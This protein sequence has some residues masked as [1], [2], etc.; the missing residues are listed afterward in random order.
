MNNWKRKAS[1]AVIILLVIIT[2]Y[3]IVFSENYLVRKAL[4]P[5]IEPDYTSN[6]KHEFTSP[7][8]RYPFLASCVFH[9]EG[10]PNELIFVGGGKGQ[11]DTILVWDGDKLES[12]IAPFSDHEATYC[13]TTVGNWDKSNDSSRI[14]FIIGRD[15]GVF[16]YKNM[17]VSSGDFGPFSKI[18]IYPKQETSIPMSVCVGDYNKDGYPD[19][20]ISNFINK[21]LTRI[22]IFN[23]PEHAK[24]NVMMSYREDGW[25]DT[26]TEL[27]L[28]GTQNTF[29]SAFVDLDNN[30]E[31]S[32]V[33]SNDTGFVEIHKRNGTEQYEIVNPGQTGYGW[34][35]GLGI[36]DVTGNGLQDIFAT[37]VGNTLPKFISRGDM[38]DEQYNQKNHSHILL[39]NR[40]NNQFVDIT[41]AAGLSDWGFGWSGVFEDMNLD[42]NLD[43]AFSQNY[44]LMNLMKS[45][46]FRLPGAIFTNNGIDDN[47]I[48]QFKRN[49]NY[50]SKGFGQTPLFADLNGNGIKDLIWVNMNGP[51]EI[52]FNKEVKNN[53]INVRIPNNFT[54]EN[55]T[56]FVE[57]R[58]GKTQFRQNIRAIGLGSD[59]SR[60]LSFGLGKNK[61]V[62]RFGIRTIYGDTFVKS[63]PEINQ[64]HMI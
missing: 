27:N 25:H 64:T 58:F 57:P 4:N 37:N 22:F 44:I 9:L 26:T 30:G 45:I 28:S 6:W 51:L 36:G 53:F 14:N 49:Y 31:L 2:V 63:N 56:V 38:T 50:L 39:A 10:M 60:I 11:D 46:T 42:G 32:L 18:E 47:G 29:Q 7:D 62:K 19:V 59:K 5:S 41:K 8:D 40:G 12:H 48:P 43:L 15:N 1:I 34:W 54:F 52:Y 33:M 24:A 23:D 55:A 20:Y 35:M 17:G 3:V 16:L 13:V 61:S 21:K